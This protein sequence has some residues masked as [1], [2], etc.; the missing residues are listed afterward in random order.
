MRNIFLFF[1]VL[2][3]VACSDGGVETLSDEAIQTAIAN[4]QVALPTNAE[5]LPTTMPE[6]SNTPLPIHTPEPTITPKPTNTPEP[7]Y[8]PTPPPDPMDFSGSGNDVLE[9]TDKWNGPGIVYVNATGRS[10][11]QIWG[12]DDT[13]DDVL[14]V[15]E[16]APFEGYNPLDFEYSFKTV[17][18][19]VDAEGPWE[20][21]IYPLSPEYIPII[22]EAP[23]STSGDGNNIIQIIGEAGLVFVNSTGDSNF[24]IWGYDDTGDDKL[25]VNEI[26]P[27]EGK[28]IIPQGI[29]LLVVEADGSWELEIYPLSPEYIPINAQAPTTITGSN[30]TVIQIIGE[31]DLLVIESTGDSNFQIWGYDDT[32]DNKLIV[33]EIAP[34]E[35]KYI[36]PQGIILLVVDADGSWEIEITAP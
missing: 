17:R 36:I 15:N 7:T 13:G 12:Y 11:F 27:F 5:V 16:I 19:Q 29:I 25:I 33:N 28:Y 26:A 22:V 32:G 23:I 18:M 34:F 10:N 30:D 9:L 6:P 31:V 1:I 24:Q 14:V 3:L 20:I 21:V 2:I 35:G 8:T 4:T